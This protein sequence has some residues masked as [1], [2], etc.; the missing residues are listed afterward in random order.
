VLYRSRINV[1]LFIGGVGGIIPKG[2]MSHWRLPVNSVSLRPAFLSRSRNA[3]AMARATNVFSTVVAYEESIIGGELSDSS[4]CKL[5]LERQKDNRR[6]SD[7]L[8]IFGTSGRPRCRRSGR[9]RAGPSSPPR[10]MN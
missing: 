10:S 9:R 5:S 3:R 7:R 1:R 8:F 2:Q 4:E 6:H